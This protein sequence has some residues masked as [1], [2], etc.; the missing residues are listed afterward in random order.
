MGPCENCGKAIPSFEKFH[1]CNTG[2]RS[3]PSNPAIKRILV[4]GRMKK[5]IQT[6]AL[7]AK[8]LYASRARRSK[9]TARKAGH[10]HNADDT[11]I[12]LYIGAVQNRVTGARARPDRWIADF[13]TRAPWSAKE[14]FGTVLQ[15][16]GGATREDVLGKTHAYG[17]RPRATLRDRAQHV[18]NGR[19]RN[20]IGIIQTLENYGKS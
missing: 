20:G 13:S 18:L 15:R 16:Q 17:K 1:Y 5:L 4:E 11:R 7:L 9:V 6:R 8:S 19:E 3:R 14:E 12:N 2:T 10:V